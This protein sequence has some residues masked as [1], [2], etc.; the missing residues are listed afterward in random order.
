MVNNT[1]STEP[2]MISLIKSKFNLLSLTYNTFHP[3]AQKYTSVGYVAG[4]QGFWAPVYASRYFYHHVFNWTN[5]DGKKYSVVI[6]PSIVYKGGYPVEDLEETACK[7]GNH[8][9]ESLTI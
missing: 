9:K 2:M 5:P 3:N 8:I 1:I 6:E 4:Y 7:L